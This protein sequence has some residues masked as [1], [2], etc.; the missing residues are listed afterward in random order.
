MKAICMPPE[1]SRIELLRLDSIICT[2]RD[3]NRGQP[4]LKAGDP[5]YGIYL[6]RTG[7]FKTSVITDSGREQITDL[8][9]TGDP[10]GLDGISAVSHRFNVIALEDSTV[11]VVPFHSFEQ[12]CS[13]SETM[14]RH[15]YRLLSDSIVREAGLAAILGTMSADQR[16]ATFLLGL[17]SAFKTRGYSEKR[18]TL[19]MS[20]EEIG[21]YLGMT[22]ETASRVLS[23]FER[24]GLLGIRGRQVHLLNLD[25]LRARGR[26]A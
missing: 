9:L 5:F 22:V 21:N 4:L 15:L 10:L 17:S 11:C 16:I 14:Q 7:C 19:R 2:K 8:N 20:R 18:F 1:I 6:V 12:L 24:N 26:A 3:I 13:E 25:A 23:K